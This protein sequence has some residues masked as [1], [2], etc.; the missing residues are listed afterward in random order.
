MKRSCF[1]VVV[2][3]MT[4]SAMVKADT[5]SVL[6]LGPLG[7]TTGV[8]A[9]GINAIGEITG[10]GSGKGFIWS[11][12][13]DV[14]YFSYGPLLPDTF[15]S[16]INNQQQVVGY[17]RNLAQPAHGFIRTSTGAMIDLGQGNIAQ[18]INDAGWVVGGPFLWTEAGGMQNF[19][20]TSGVLSYDAY[21]VNNAGQIVGQANFSLS[22]G[23]RAFVWSSASGMQAL[24]SFAG[25]GASA[26]NG[27]N[28]AGQV[29]GYCYLSGGKTHGFKWTSKN[30]M[31]DLG[32][33]GGANSNAIAIN[34]RGDVLGQ[35]DTA[36]GQKKNV[37]WRGTAITDLDDALSSNGWT[38]ATVTGMNDSGQIVGYGWHGG[39][40]S[41]AFVMTPH[42][43]LK[44]P[45][46][47]PSAP[48]KAPALPTPSANA[49]GL[50]LI[51]HGWNSNATS[52]SWV[53]NLAS[54]ERGAI[55][56][57]GTNDW[58]VVAY[59]WSIQAKTD[60]PVQAANNAAT[61]GFEL[62]RIL[63]SS[64][65][66]QI[67]IVA[68]S[69]GAWMADAIARQLKG[70]GKTIDITF[71][72]AFVPFSVPNPTLG[73]NAR[74]AEQYMDRRLPAYEETLGRAANPFWLNGR[75]GV[76]LSNAFNVEVSQRDPNWDPNYL[77]QPRESLAWHE[78]PHDFYN[79][80]LGSEWGLDLSPELGRVPSHTD[81]NF[82]RNT[83][84]ELSRL[85]PV[86]SPTANSTPM[87]YRRQDTVL[88]P[89]GLTYQFGEL[90]GSKIDGTS[91]QFRTHSPNWFAAIVPVNNVVNAVEFDMRFTSDLGAE[92]LLSVYWDGSLIGTIDER[93]AASELQHYV[94]EL[95]GI[96][97]TNEYTL[98]FRL[99]P[100]SPVSSSVV[101]DNMTTSYS[102]MIELPEPSSLLGLVAVMHILICRRFNRA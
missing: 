37:L 83:T 90:D 4:Y 72:D 1:F 7:G 36:T 31:Q 35:A 27:I 84:V 97:N 73:K 28:S 80:S 50:V 45:N 58:D 57:S 20:A 100:Y 67:H 59:D 11:P 49:T 10:T 62:G 71:L 53:A 5:Y 26:A 34:S 51:T 69:A 74:F 52:G 65:Y 19:A 32:T 17:M 46:D 18:S 92:G 102:G 43:Q 23:N 48:S 60:N 89:S 54:T 82:A 47:P 93:Y 94:F 64:Q 55:Q 29:V 87:Y 24:E 95:P 78:W 12:S 91:I 81:P 6:D 79:Q 88:T 39:A 21:S 99:D 25:G 61:I 3:S 63:T 86:A 98:A 14:N 41:R 22:I 56:N 42:P 2:V 68:H 33:L 75:T 70:S 66:Q 40:Y 9:A 77:I 13:G 8:Y 44:L 76:S 38:G 85:T 101:I 15:P 16:A 30:G 96:Y